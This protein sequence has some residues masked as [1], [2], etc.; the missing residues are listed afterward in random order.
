MAGGASNSLC[1]CVMCGRVAMAGG[2]AGQNVHA[3]LLSGTADAVLW[4]LTG[5]VLASLTVLWA[6]KNAVKI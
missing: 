3:N 2:V 6:V 4:A 1:G 5:I